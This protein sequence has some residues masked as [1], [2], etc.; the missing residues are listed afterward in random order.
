MPVPPRIAVRP[1][2]ATS[3]AKPR[4]GATFFRDGLTKGPPT[5]VAE[6]VTRSGRYAS[7]PFFSDGTEYVSYRAPRFSVSLPFTRQSSCRYTPTIVFGRS[8]TRMEPGSTPWNWRA[9]PARNDVRFAKL[10]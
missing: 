2:P 8:R 7:N 3:Q 4:R 9:V 6:L 10:Y 5:T 1:S